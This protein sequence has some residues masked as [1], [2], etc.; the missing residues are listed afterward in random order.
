MKRTSSPERPRASKSRALLS[1]AVT[2]AL[3]VA[4]T[5]LGSTALAAAPPS[6][7]RPAS[8]LA[9][10]TNHTCALASDGDVVCWGQNSYGQLGDGST[11]DRLAPVAVANAGTSIAVAAGDAHSCSLQ[12]NGTVMCW[13]DN[14]VGQLGNGTFTGSSVPVTVSG[15][16]GNA[17]P[18]I[19]IT[20]GAYHTCAILSD[21]TA[22][23]WGGN[24][25]GALGDGTT[26]NR[27]APVTV[28]GL[29]SALAITAGSE[30]TCAIDTLGQATCWGNN[31]E[32]ALGDGTTT[33]RLSP[34][35]V[36]GI[37]HG[38]SRLAVAISAGRSHTCA[39]VLTGPSIGGASVGSTVVCWGAGGRGQLGNGG[40]TGSTTPVVATGVSSVKDLSVNGDHSCALLADGTAKCWG[41]NS[42]GEAGNGTS[43]GYQATAVVASG[44]TGARA[45]AAGYFHSCAVL[46]NGTASC[47]GG[48]LRGQLGSGSFTS[49][50]VPGPV[51]GLPLVSIGGRVSAGLYHSCGVEPNGGVKCWGNNVDGQVGDGSVTQRNAP[52]VSGV[53]GVLDVCAGNY[54]S[55]ALLAD[56]TAKCW[57]YNTFG[58]AGT[59]SSSPAT[60]PTPGSPVLGLT[61]AVAI[62]CGAYHSCATLANGTQKCWGYNTDGELGNSSTTAS[63]SPVQVALASGQALDYVR[64][65]ASGL[66]HLCAARAGGQVSCW[67]YNAFGEIGD[68]TT[69][70]RTSPVNITLGGAA[71]ARNM[72]LG[73]FHSCAVTAAGAPQCWGYNGYGQ[74]GNNSTVNATT[75]TNVLGISIAAKTGQL[76]GGAYHT[77]AMM[78]DSS[79]YCWGY[80]AHGQLGEGTTTSR[81]L[82]ALLPFIWYGTALSAGGYHTCLTA[83]DDT[84]RCWGY[85]AYGE[86]G[87]GGVASYSTPVSVTGFP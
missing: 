58:Q 83:T 17:T 26:T 81:S 38:N 46:A 29:A 12:W 44:L 77:C 76:V 13:G 68:A 75:P 50:S 85:G 63:A 64:T 31:F 40:V 47:W 22:R 4:A 84:A 66:Y 33:N 7:E 52:V 1:R 6:G 73:G 35:V 19:A 62:Q 82:P 3:V 86:L 16:G 61:G 30:H 56:G 14:A 54:H 18:A 10:G 41:E 23:C 37:A 2:P 20:A 59:G 78:G 87:T 79:I 74:V 11:A 69:T 27:S 45:I 80:N 25:R 70:N 55:C 57:G 53:S 51:T 42:D 8:F 28:T 48:N 15:I 36:S 24:A 34:A 67:G 5:L 71:T 65:T 21:G 49:Q 39:Q 72:G 43:G 9:G 60:I 32:G